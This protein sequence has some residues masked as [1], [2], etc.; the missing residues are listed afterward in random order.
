MSV[1]A[2]QCEGQ[3]C[4]AICTPSCVAMRILLTLE[5]YRAHDDRDRGVVHSRAR[6]FQDQV[7]MLLLGQALVGFAGPDPELQRGEKQTNMGTASASA[8]FSMCGRE[9]F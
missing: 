5:A 2:G 7:V 3:S 9:S 8:P 1:A 6:Y 4:C